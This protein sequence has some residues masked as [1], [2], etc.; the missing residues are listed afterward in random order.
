MLC[1]VWLW[2]GSVAADADAPL[3]QINASLAQ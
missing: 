3:H 1:S 2:V